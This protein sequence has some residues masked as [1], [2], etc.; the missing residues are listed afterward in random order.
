M[1][2]VEPES[3]EN[4]VRKIVPRQ[5]RNW[6][7]SP[8]RSIEW[9]QDAALFSLGITKQLQVTKDWRMTCHPHMYKIARRDQLRDPEQ[10]REFSNFLS[11]C[12]PGMRLLDIGAH[13]GMFSFA[14]ASVGG[15][16]IAIDPS[17]AAI[18]MIR[19]QSEL[20]GYADRLRIM[21]AAVSDHS[22]VLELLSSGV[23]ADGYFRVASGRL[24]SDLTE[25]PATTVDDL[26]QEFGVPTH[27]KI[28]V[29]GHEGAVLRGGLRTLENYAPIL[30]LELHNEMVA[31]EA[32]DPESTLNE[33][34]RLGFG[35]F[36]TDGSPLSRKAIL[37]KPIIRIVCKRA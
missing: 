26:V 35:K 1:T 18:R 6:L 20:N 13:F 23:F 11:H 22:G 4:Y 17:P 10:S 34:D 30:F 29:E 9:L 15:N 12:L 14:A 24:K 33:L 2:T 27:I 3:W 32:G 16:A 25:I 37:E 36:A 21:R 28:D 19:V 8:S 5:V 7:R 31:A